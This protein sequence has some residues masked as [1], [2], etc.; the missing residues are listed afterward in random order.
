MLLDGTCINPEYTASVSSGVLS[1]ILNVSPE[2][3]QAVDMDTI[4]SPI[5]YSFV[6]GMPNNYK[7]FFEI[8]P[9]SGAVRQIKAVDTAVTKKFDIIIKAQ[10]VSEARRSTTAKLTI[11]VKPVDS[12]PPVIHASTFEG[13]VNENAPI[14][15]EVIDKD[16]NPLILTV[17]DDDLVS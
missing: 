9:T 12:S 5:K 6:S 7:E 1:G 13:F 14:G 10:E 15:T 16:G 11:T 4:N 3:I 2:K 17:T 8:N